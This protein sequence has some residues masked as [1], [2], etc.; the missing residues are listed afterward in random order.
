MAF[1]RS[2]VRS[3]LSPPRDLER[4]FRVFL[5]CFGLRLGGAAVE[6]RAVRTHKSALTSRANHATIMPDKAV[7][8]TSRYLE[9]LQRIPA[10]EKGCRNRYFVPKRG[11]SG[12]GTKLLPE[13]S[14]NTLELHTERKALPPCQD[15]DGRAHYSARVS[16][17]PPGNARTRRG[18][19]L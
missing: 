2:A 7:K 10:A 8:R 12:R 19:C 9:M 15:Y 6:Q 16:V 18:L 13:K 3:R 5:F 1:K 4:E 17:F 11:R 14:K